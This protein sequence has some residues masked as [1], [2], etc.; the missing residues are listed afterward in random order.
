MH[1]TPPRGPYDINER[2][3]LNESLAAVAAKPE[4][5]GAL[6]ELQDQDA[7]I[8][9]VANQER[10]IV[11]NVRTELQTARTLSAELHERA[12]AT[13]ATGHLGRLDKLSSRLRQAEQ[14]AREALNDSDGQIPDSELIETLRE[15]RRHRV[16]AEDVLSRGL[17]TVLKAHRLEATW[18]SLQSLLRPK[19]DEQTKLSSRDKVLL[20]LSGEMTELSTTLPQVDDMRFNALLG[21]LPQARKD[22]EFRTLEDQWK[23]CRE[24]LVRALEMAVHSIFLTELNSAVEMHYGTSMVVRSLDRFKETLTKDKMVKTVAFDELDVLMKRRNGGSFGVSGPR[25]VGKSTLIEFFTAADANPDGEPSDPPQKPRLGIHVSAPV[26]YDRR[27]FILHLHAELCR[28]I[29]GDLSDAELPVVSGRGWSSRRTIGQLA[30]LVATFSGALLVLTGSAFLSYF[31]RSF[32]ESVDALGYTA[33][34]LLACAAMLMALFLVN[35]L[36]FA[37]TIFRVRSIVPTNDE[38]L[39]LW[40]RKLSTRRARVSLISSWAFTVT[41]VAGIVIFSRASLAWADTWPL[42][43]GLLTATLGMSV[44]YGVWYRTRMVHFDFVDSRI[45]RS[46]YSRKLTEDAI[47]QLKR[48]YYQQGFTSERSMSGKVGGTVK[49]PVALEV[50]GKEGATLSERELTYP[51]IVMGLKRF[52]TIIAQEVDLVVAID[53]LDKMHNIDA[54]QEFLNE[55]KGVFGVSGCIFLV[56]VSEDAAASFERRGMPFRDVFDS[57]FDEIVTLERMGLNE[58][59]QILYGLLLGWTE[60]FVGLCYALSGGLPR[61]LHRSARLLVGGLQE[62]SKIH[63][64]T[65][66]SEIFH[67]E[68]NA[69]LRAV[70][71]AVIADPLDA[72]GIALLKELDRIE[73]AGPVTAELLF[74]WRVRLQ[75]WVA[76]QAELEAFVRLPRAVRLGQEL[77]AFMYFALTVNEFFDADQITRRM[78]EVKES[79]SGAKSLNRLAYARHTIALDP[80]ASMFC[81]RAFREAWGLEL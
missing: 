21:H 30:L 22:V 80:G 57:S 17:E 1:R 64:S 67:R 2:G 33:I 31:A 53:E 16:S 41:G 26:K 60:P 71:H 24:D 19:T 25:G 46:R 14:R 42:L 81:T 56:S 3:L 54:V 74:Q 44:L 52:M 61:D 49:I 9:S 79:G 51:E 58:A 36:G 32:K 38:S 55:V 7:I 39:L 73:L 35:A 6:Q 15:V 27:E 5:A 12:I 37:A 18:R 77:E 20:D 76:G 72:A 23:A 63:L 4:I 62:S 47:E 11:H 66:L 13:D 75:R 28:T 45:S 69:R 48:I 65:A 50:G 68:C 29:L 78:K 8:S 34:S 59:R 40:M 10:L 70:R 43:A